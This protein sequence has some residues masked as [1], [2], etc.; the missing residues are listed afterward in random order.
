MFE[1]FFDVLESLAKDPE[2]YHVFYRSFCLLGSRSLFLNKLAVDF[3]KKIG[4]SENLNSK[5]LG[6]QIL[7]E[8]LSDFVFSRL[9]NKD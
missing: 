2:L 6:G 4:A 8:L 1:P 5:E 9:N 3:A 7:D